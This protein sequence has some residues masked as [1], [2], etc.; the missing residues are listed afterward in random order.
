MGYGA[1]MVFVG[2]GDDQADERFAAL[3]D[4]GRVGHHHFDLGV[5]RTAEANAAI[6]GEPASL[7]A[8]EVEVHANLARPAEGQE[9]K[10]YGRGVH[11]S[12]QFLN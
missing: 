9:G 3:R 10:I 8:I 4:E 7:V 11:N 5:R 12:V 2:V 1:D 6:D